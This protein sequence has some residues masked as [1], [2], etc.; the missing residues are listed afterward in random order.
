MSKL[1][2][3]GLLKKRSETVAR[4]HAAQEEAVRLV[5]QLDHIDATIRMFKPDIDF[6]GMPMK[7]LPPPHAAFRGDFARSLLDMLRWKDQQW[8]TTD[9]LCVK[10]MVQRRMNELDLPLRVLV[11][12][13]VGHSLRGLRDKGMVKSRKHG[14]GTL[15]AWK[16]T[17]AD[18]Q[19]IGGWRNG[20]S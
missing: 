10:V 2:I 3:S 13:R 6:D 7:L 17:R 15:L 19:L 5:V 20:N 9:E 12:K 16:I 11:R 4:I 8:Q 18:A 14:K 1:T